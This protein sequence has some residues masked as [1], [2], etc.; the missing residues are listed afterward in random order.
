MKRV[1]IATLGESPPVVTE[2]LDILRG[3]GKRI[4]EVIL[5]TTIDAL[6]MDAVDLLV[7]HIP[8]YYG[9]QTPARAFPIEAYSDIDNEEALVMFMREACGVLRGHIKAGDEVYV[10]ISGGR[11]TMSALMTL[12]VQFYG[13][14]ELFHIIVTDPELEEKSNITKLRHLKEQERNRVL[15][16]DLSK[17]KII[18]MPFIGLFPWMSDIVA[19]LKGE[20]TPKKEIQELLAANNLL[21]NGKLT[22][23]GEIFLKII[24]KVESRPP[25]RLEEPKIHIAKHHHQKE[26]QQVAQ[27]IVNRLNY[28]TQIRSIEWRGGK[29]RV[30][31]EPPNRLRIYIAS[32]KGYNLGLLLETTA[33]TEGQ[34][35]VA[36]KE[37]KDILE[38]L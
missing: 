26:L 14:R 12:A 21:E 37:A 7:K 28:V 25:P 33:E 9:R 23:L 1:L 38:E 2:A 22:P 34:L 27:K 16:P 24:E 15:H 31:R 18:Q 3:E 4:D 5:L 17:V 30:Q 19:A 6:T 8:E 35:S 10:S 36:E 20:Q 13:A 29:E 11:K 32:G